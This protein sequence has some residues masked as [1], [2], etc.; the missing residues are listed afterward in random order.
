MPQREVQ[1]LIR[2]FRRDQV[3][4]TALQIFGRSGTLDVSMDEIAAEAGVSRSTIYNHFR[5][6][7]ELLAACAEWSYG[8]L[9]GAMQKSLEAGGEPVDLVTGFFAAVFRCLDENPGFYRLATTLRSSSDDAEAV[10]DLQLTAAA[11]LSRE[12]IDQLVDRLLDDV[13]LVADRDA[14]LTLIGV[15]LSGSLQRRAMLA[16]PPP[17]H[18]AAREVA[19]MLLFGL[20]KR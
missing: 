11:S 17:A 10:L 15:V 2:G 14:V 5:D 7:A 1:D 18:A 16:D 8:H 13:A 20:V 4:T 12:Q 9:A 6:R 3:V 19:G